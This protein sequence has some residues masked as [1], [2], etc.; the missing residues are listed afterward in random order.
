MVNFGSRALH[1]GGEA[2]S[3]ELEA[4][5]AESKHS[6]DAEQSQDAGHSADEPLVLKFG[7]RALHKGRAPSP[8]IARL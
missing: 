4:H 5:S 1:K 3:A 6:R 2:R 8:S 7:S